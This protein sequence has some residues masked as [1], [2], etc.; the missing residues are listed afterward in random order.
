VRAVPIDDLKQLNVVNST[1]VT[2]G[3]L[4]EAFSQELGLTNCHGV[5][6]MPEDL[7][8]LEKIYY[9]KVGPIF[10][11]YLCTL[12]SHYDTTSLRGLMKDIPEPN[13]VARLP[14]LLR[15]AAKRNFVSFDSE[16][17]KRQKAKGATESQ[18]HLRVVKPVVDRPKTIVIVGTGYVSFFAFKK[19]YSKLRRQILSGEIRV[20]VV[21]MSNFHAFHGFVGEMIGGQISAQSTRSPVRNI[22]EGAEV[23]RG[24]VEHIDP[25][26]Q[27]ILVRAGERELQLEYDHLVY[28]L[29]SVTR[30]DK[31]PGLARHGWTLRGE[32]TVQGFQNQLLEMLEAASL[33]SNPEKRRK[34]LNIV[35]V[36][37]GFTGVEMAAA[38]AEY[39]EYLKDYYP[40]L[41]TDP[42]QVFLC[43]RGEGILKE[44]RSKYSRLVRYASKHLEKYDVRVLSGV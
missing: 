31:V 38:L 2:S 25:N 13:L 41:E 34:L 33:E 10:S 39:L 17:R 18:T 42:A 5:P 23:I 9:D 27:N 22:F 4:L 28:G 11:P 43:N 20:Q 40:V 8:D 21:G 30:N 35:I 16:K 29:G 36:G 26:A 6:D 1:A 44:I 37:A 14:E 7:N 19:L 12:P 3:E 24:K 32:G 15:Y